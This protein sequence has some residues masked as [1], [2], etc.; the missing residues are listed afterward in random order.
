MCL[1]TY[2]VYQSEGWWFDPGSSGLHVE[3]SLGKVLNP[4][5]LSMAAPLVCECVCL[6]S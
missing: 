1:V 2:E 4:K 3:V 5:L 6:S